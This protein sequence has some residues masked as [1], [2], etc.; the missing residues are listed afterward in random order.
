MELVPL[1]LLNP[2]PFNVGLSLGAGSRAGLD[3]ISTDVVTGPLGRVS[4][5]WT[6]Q[7]PL[8]TRDRFPS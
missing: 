4:A 7:A 2:D 8:S 5:A 1:E 3:F 6:L